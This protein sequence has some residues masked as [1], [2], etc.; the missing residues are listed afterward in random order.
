MR[1]KGY[2]QIN[3][4][5]SEHHPQWTMRCAG[6]SSGVTEFRFH[7]YDFLMAEEV[8]YSIMPEQFR[9][10]FLAKSLQLG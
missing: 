1:D 7:A 3:S 4:G 2:I 6:K 8:A 5:Y 10:T 9:L